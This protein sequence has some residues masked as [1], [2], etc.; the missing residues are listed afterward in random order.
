MAHQPERKIMDL[1]EEF[2]KAVEDEFKRQSDKLFS[3]FFDSNE[4][5]YL[6][7]Y[8]FIEESRELSWFVNADNDGN[9]MAEG[10]YTALDALTPTRE[11]EPHVIPVNVTEL[12]KEQIEEGRDGCIEPEKPYLANLLAALQRAAAMVQERIDEI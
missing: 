5:A 11:I 10:R 6:I 9:F 3:D 7:A 8:H 12:I 1:S 4:Y 2:Q